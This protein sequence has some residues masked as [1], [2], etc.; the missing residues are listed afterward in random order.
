[1]PVPEPP[2]APESPISD[3]AVARWRRD[4]MPAL[5]ASNAQLLVALLLASFPAQWVS[6]ESEDVIRR[7]LV[8]RHQRDVLEAI[9][10]LAEEADKV[11]VK[12]LIELCDER[13]TARREAEAAAAEARRPKPVAPPPTAR[14]RLI[15]EASIIR[16]LVRVERA[17]SGRIVSEEEL[18][19][20]V[21]ELR[22]VDDAE[23]AARASDWAAR[24]AR[25]SPGPLSSMV[26]A[27][28]RNGLDD[29]VVW[30]RYKELVAQARNPQP[31]PEEEAGVRG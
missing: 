30:A 25:L 23:L 22:S 7:R 4:P 19:H 9:E 29:P 1:M 6:P 17:S 21:E 28:S 14:A 27:E 18:E 16:A 11:S 13:R 31:R 12:R 2:R 5:D 20:I 24:E 26:A 8:G 3:R 10:A 15:M